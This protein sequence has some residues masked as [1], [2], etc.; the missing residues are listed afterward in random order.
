LQDT[1]T[2]AQGLIDISGGQIRAGVYHADVK[3][4]QKERLHVRWRCGEIKVVCATIGT[5][6]THAYEVNVMTNHVILQPLVWA[7][8]RY[9]C[10][11]FV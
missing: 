8:T 7:L 4:A 10:N 11:M 1:E 6:I 3:D 2:V 9:I 5:A